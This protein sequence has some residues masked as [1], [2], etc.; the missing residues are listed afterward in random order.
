MDG[1][2]GVSNASLIGHGGE[3]F[4]RRLLRKSSAEYCWLIVQHVSRAFPVGGR[5]PS[6]NTCWFM[7]P[8][9]VSKIR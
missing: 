8:R 1:L 7:S 4:F 6:G 3:A 9:C 2:L 5:L